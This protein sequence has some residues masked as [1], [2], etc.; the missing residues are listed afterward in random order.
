M[1]LRETESQLLILNMNLVELAQ[2]G[3]SIFAI[4]CTYLIAKMFINFIKVQEKNY[5]DLVKNHLKSETKAK[6]KM[7]KS[8]NR[9]ANTIEEL[10][11]WLKGNNK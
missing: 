11:K 2:F 7:E 5:T 10:L 9:L 8:F 3:P 4:A 1:L 6:I